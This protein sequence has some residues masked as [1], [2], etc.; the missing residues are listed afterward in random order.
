[1]R[2]LSTLITLALTGTTGYLLV[3]KTLE[4]NPD[5]PF[6]KKMA[7]IAEICNEATPYINNP[8]RFSRTVGETVTFREPK[9]ARLLK[10]AQEVLGISEA[11][12]E[13]KAINKLR[14]QNRKLRKEITDLKKKRLIV[15]KDS[16]IPFTTTQTSINKEIENLENQI[17]ENREKVEVIKDKIL[18]IFFEHNLKLQE[19][20][21]EYFLISAEGD[22]LLTLMTIANNMKRIQELIEKELATDPNNVE[23]AKSYTG[24]YLVS[25]DSYCNAHEAVISNIRKYRDKLDGIFLEAESNYN[26]ALRLKAHSDHANSAHIESNLSLNKKTL[27][28]VKLYDGLL[29]RRIANLRS[30]QGSVAQ[31]VK[32]A[33]NTYKTLDNGSMLINLVAKAGEEYS[34]VINFEMP[35]L[36]SIYDTGMLN[37]FMDIAERIR[38][39]K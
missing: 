27:E 39:E 24:M 5:S 28:I 35:E 9:Y 19:K 36:K 33:R 37:A 12:D 29:E 18:E 1:M 3:K 11:E 6:A 22:D 14:L 16:S 2:I 17:N 10:E 13:F 21:L 4:N 32:I 26:E 38:D 23:L 7:R 15:P 34:L 8:E 31:K 25:L 20:E 30:S